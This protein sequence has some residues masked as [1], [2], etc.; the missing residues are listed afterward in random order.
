MISRAYVDKDICM[1]KERK[2]NMELHQKKL[3]EIKNKD[4]F[5]KLS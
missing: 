5:Y 4:G 1:E 3:G 2:R